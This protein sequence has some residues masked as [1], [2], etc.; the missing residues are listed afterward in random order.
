M[1]YYTYTTDLPYPS[2]TL[3]RRAYVKL[4][5]SILLPPYLLINPYF[6]DYTDAIDEVFDP[7]VEAKIEALTNIRNMWLTNKNT[8]EKINNGAM[9]D[10]TDW[11]GPERATVVAQVNLLGMK[12]ATAG[13]V[14]EN[15]YRSISRFLGQYWFEKG[16]ATAMDFLNF[17]LGTS[18]TI[19]KMW[20]K[21]YVDFY[22]ETNPIVGA[23]VYDTP[24]GEWY[25]T[26]HMGI[27]IPGD[28]VINPIVL[29][30]FFYEICNY[31]LVLRIITNYYDCQ[32]ITSDSTTQANLVATAA[33]GDQIWDFESDSYL[34][35]I[36]TND[37]VVAASTGVI[38]R[39]YIYMA[40][41]VA[42]MT[43]PY[44]L[45]TKALN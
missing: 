14:S 24:A 36:E 33:E 3:N 15:A 35:P 6:V 37:E 28:Y 42:G 39:G 1:T 41:Y 2:A 44:P 10:I 43:E 26:T 20:T 32:I 17:C 5:R 30:N 45:N 13:V 4:P 23:K 22:E 19:S 27:T 8:E 31:N 40:N 16:K 21:D 12:L 18:F 7:W 38:L 34:V 9:L 29:S 11:G 25:P